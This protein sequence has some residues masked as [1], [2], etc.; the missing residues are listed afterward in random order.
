MAFQQDT[1]EQGSSPGWDPDYKIPPSSYK[2]IQYI[3]H[4]CITEVHG[5]LGF[6]G[7]KA[8]LDY[9]P[10][11]LQKQQN[12]GHITNIMRMSCPYL[13]TLHCAPRG[14]VW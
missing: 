11:H 12:V 13:V 1:S 2:H 4:T 8:V 9:P 5:L 3:L 6:E 7:T 10:Y 14:C